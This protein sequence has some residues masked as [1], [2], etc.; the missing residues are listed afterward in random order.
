MAL[1]FLIGILFYVDLG[2]GI[3]ASLLCL[4]EKRLLGASVLIVAGYAYT[5][6]SC[7][8]TADLDEVV[9]SALF[10][11]NR[12]TKQR[13]HFSRRFVY[14]GVVRVLV[15]SEGKRFRRLPCRFYIPVG[16][17]RPPASRDYFLADVRLIRTGAHRFVLKKGRSVP[18]VPVE[19]SR[20]FAEY[21]FR[22]KERV[23]RYVKGKI[24]DRSV[25]SLAV[26]LLTG[27]K[28]S[29]LQ[30]F[31]FNR[32]GL[33]HLLAI[34]GFHFAILALF[35]SL[36]LR[37]L[38][39]KRTVAVIL[40]TALSG[41]S[42][43]MGRSPSI[44]RA[45][46]GFLFLLAG[47]VLDRKSVAG[48]ALGL[49]LLSASIS[50]PYAITHPGFMLSFFATAGILFLYAPCERWLRKIFPKRSSEEM[51][52]VPWR[53]FAGSAVAHALRK[54]LALNGAVTLCTLPVILFHF[55]VFPLIGLFYNL[56]FPFLFS[57][58]IGLFL[59]ALVLPFLFPLFVA[60]GGFLLDL[61]TYTPKKWL[62]P[63]RLSTVPKEGVA[64]LSVA[65]FVWSMYWRWKDPPIR[66]W[67]Y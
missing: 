19:G 34:S 35:L 18:W 41:Y 12:V 25:R 47:Y 1:F 33:G 2:C 3:A 40:I 61:I 63:F 60:Y 39:G 27:E 6:L 15:E 66:K 62:L 59:L 31:L 44:S 7:A 32:V 20:S 58:L 49:G 67:H 21:R 64:L 65:L 55:G 36:L 54:A 5:F 9:G 53:I 14:E 38:F 4:F 42:L 10:H 26:G 56:F 51:E 22:M 28:E 24:D 48:N 11:I 46:I 57:M 23:V 8:G 52:G 37:P 45:W 30:A 13:T 29:L 50:D 43:Y 17:K 16:K